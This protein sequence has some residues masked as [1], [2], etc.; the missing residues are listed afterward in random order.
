MTCA[1]GGKTTATHLEGHSN[2]LLRS[3]DLS[4]LVSTLCR[5]A[6]DRAPATPTCVPN[7]V[8]TATRFGGQSEQV[9]ALTPP[10]PMATQLASGQTGWPAM[11]MRQ[12]ALC[13]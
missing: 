5:G 6:T 4:L 1:D 13:G 3:P 7:G 9:S 2:V 12:T 8:A 11:T 10:G